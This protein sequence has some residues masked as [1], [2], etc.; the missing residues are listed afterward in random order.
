VEGALM[1]ISFADFTNF[2]VGRTAEKGKYRQILLHEE[3]CSI[4]PVYEKKY[5]EL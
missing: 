4:I 2:S 1:R 3:F 5:L